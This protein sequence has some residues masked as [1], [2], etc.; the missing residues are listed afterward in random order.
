ML[1]AR[2]PTNNVIEVVEGLPLTLKCPVES[3]TDLEV[4]WVKNGSFIQNDRRHLI[5]KKEELHI[6]QT[7]K[8]NAGNYTCIAFN[9][10]GQVSMSYDVRILGR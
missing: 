7:S 3:N 10:A 8:D 9:D 4:N 5:N 2:S 6:L 1:R